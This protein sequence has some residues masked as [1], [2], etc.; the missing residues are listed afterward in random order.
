MY[1]VT[2]VA[3][4]GWGMYGHDEL[5]R[6]TLEDTLDA[7]YAYLLESPGDRLKLR[8]SKNIVQAIKEG[9]LKM[10]VWF[11]ERWSQFDQLARSRED[12]E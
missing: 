4:G 2:M 5:E 1:Q 10:S 11:P 9:D 6:E 12:D 3:V 8:A 7:I